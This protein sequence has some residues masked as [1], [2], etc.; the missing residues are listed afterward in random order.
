MTALDD[1][2]TEQLLSRVAAG[3]RTA[4]GLLLE[5]HRR[6]LRHMITIRLDPQL[7]ARVDP[8]DVVQESLAEADQKLSDYLQERPV[9]FY[10]WLRSLAWKHLVHLHRRHIYSQRRS[11]RREQAA[12]LR[13]SDESRGGSAGTAGNCM[14]ELGTECQ[15]RTSRTG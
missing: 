12:R 7:R 9:P 10:P 14:M 1:L 11:V 3:D 2:N 4:R 15:Q 6:R 13:L 5:R 8:S